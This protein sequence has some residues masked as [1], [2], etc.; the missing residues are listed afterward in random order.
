MGVKL[1]I[2][3]LPQKGV[4][5]PSQYEL[6]KRLVDEL[7]PT[8]PSGR[9]DAW[10]VT[11]QLLKQGHALMAAM[12]GAGAAPGGGLKDMW[13]VSFR[14]SPDQVYL[15]VRPEHK[16]IECD[17]T[18][19]RLLEKKLEYGKQMTIRLEGLTYSKGDFLL[20]LITAT[21][22]IHSSQALLGHC[23]EVEYVPLSSMQAAEGCMADFVELLRQHLLASGALGGLE[24]L[25][26]GG[27]RLGAQLE[28]VKPSYDKYGLTGL[29]YGRTHAAVAYGDLVVAMLNTSAAAAQAA[30]V[31]AQQQ[32][33]QQQLQQQ[34]QFGMVKPA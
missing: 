8:P 32:Q 11:C 19:M 20:R 5:G 28:L 12:G 21:Q 1:L 16:A 4:T 29:P 26:G 7:C 22:A 18:I 3:T 10:A 30:A 6:L 9:S 27:G 31:A 34:Q 2:R 15:L 25:G 33:Q 17:A 13:A 24:T 23:L 14:D